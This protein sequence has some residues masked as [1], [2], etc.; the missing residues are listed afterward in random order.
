[1][2]HRTDLNGV[3]RLILRRGQTFSISLYLRSGSYQPEVSA[4]DLVAETGA[5]P[6]ALREHRIPVIHEF[7]CSGFNSDE[8]RVSGKQSET[9]PLPFVVFKMRG[10]SFGN[11]A[12]K[13]TETPP[14]SL[15]LKSGFF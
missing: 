13:E 11:V 14:P 2:E 15:A 7:W 5:P 3:D 4:L 12:G 6:S 8:S 9:T 10:E 1:M